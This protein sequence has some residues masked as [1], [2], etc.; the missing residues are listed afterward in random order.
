MRRP[1]ITPQLQALLGSAREMSPEARVRQATSFAY[2]NLKLE[3]E[4]VT[5]AQVVAATHAVLAA[6]AEPAVPSRARSR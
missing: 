1:A 3:D 4:G 5:K 2:G 6:D